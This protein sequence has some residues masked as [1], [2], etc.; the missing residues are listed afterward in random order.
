M[1]P[2]PSASPLFFSC[3]LVRCQVSVECTGCVV[4]G[5]HCGSS[6]SQ[7]TLYTKDLAI[8][9]E[10]RLA[11]LF[12]HRTVCCLDLDLS[13]CEEDGS[14]WTTTSSGSSAQSSHELCMAI[15]ASAELRP[16]MS[17]EDGRRVDR[18]ERLTDDRGTGSRRSTSPVSSISWFLL[19]DTVGPQPRNRMVWSGRI[20]PRE[21]G[22]VW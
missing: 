7:Q 6:A 17:L 15:T 19:F 3:F 21:I 10:N 18:W 9:A 5:A 11:R 4:T 2:S 22:I 8:F 12:L 1:R 13:H 14:R 20:V 16:R